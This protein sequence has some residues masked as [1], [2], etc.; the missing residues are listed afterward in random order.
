MVLRTWPETW[1][2]SLL[3]ITVSLLL[4]ARSRVGVEPVLSG[5]TDIAGISCVLA[6]NILYSHLSPFIIYLSY[7]IVLIAPPDVYRPS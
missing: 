7:M 4:S 3:G 6:I 1:T 5:A 2:T